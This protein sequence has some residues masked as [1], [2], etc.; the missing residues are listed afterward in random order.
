MNRLTRVTHS[1]SSFVQ[2]GY[3][4]RG[5][6]TSVTDGNGK[7]TQYAYDDA[8]R[9]I[10]VTDAQQPFAGVTEYQYD[11]ESNLKTKIDRRGH[12][13]TLNYDSLDRMTSKLLDDGILYTSSVRSPCCR[14]VHRPTRATGD[15]H[16]RCRGDLRR[17]GIAFDA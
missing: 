2:Y 14:P 17:G 6:R 16:R 4:H 11:T 9:Q 3:D 5:R 13:T 8:D 12:T 1:D 10:S 15:D 7:A